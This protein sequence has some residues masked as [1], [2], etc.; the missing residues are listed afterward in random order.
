MLLWIS[1]SSLD[2]IGHTY[3][4]NSFEVIDMIYH[5]DSQIQE[6]MDYAQSEVGRK[7]VLFVLTADHG[8]SPIID[9]LKDKNENL[10]FRL[11]DKDL[12]KEMNELIEKKYHITKI[13]R[14]FKTNQFYLD[15]EILKTITHEQK[16]AILADLK[17][18]LLQK[19]GITN[20]WAYE[21]LS[22]KTYSED[23]PEN[24]FKNQLYLGRSGDLICMTLP[25]CNISK[26][27]HGTNHRTPYEFDTHVPL[28]IYQ[29]GTHKKKQVH[30]Q[31]Y[32]TQ[33]IGTLAKV[34]GI[35]PPSNAN[36]KL[37]PGIMN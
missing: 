10:A 20:A 15:K 26:Y 17:E 36:K 33:L 35:T 19:Q 12:K 11:S 23:Q 7:N 29:A 6:F 37:L 31:V 30:S 32:V 34:M 5:L 2:M 22:C 18:I 4:P 8:V 16:T 24:Y 13:V 14:S 25:F 1:L 27:E 9:E 3:G 21:E 28:F